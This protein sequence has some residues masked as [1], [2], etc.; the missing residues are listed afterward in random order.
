M[1]SEENVHFENL[2]E[3][4]DINLLNLLVELEDFVELV[5]SVSQPG[6]CGTSRLRSACDREINAPNRYD[7][8]TWNEILRLK[9]YSS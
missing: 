8:F 7:S 6:I 1:S 4:A 5:G 3:D 9:C 2:E